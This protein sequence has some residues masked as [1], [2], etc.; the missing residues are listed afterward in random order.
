MKKRIA[1]ISS[2]IL[3]AAALVAAPVVFAQM[4]GRH[5]GH[6][7]GHAGGMGMLGMLD[8]FGQVREQLGLTDEQVGK[9][10]T[11]FGDLREQNEA[12]HEQMHGTLKDVA[13]TLIA[14]PNDV[15]AA[16]AKIEAQTAAEN[17]MKLNALNAASKALNVLT[18]EQRTKLGALLDEHFQQMESRRK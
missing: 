18:P 17:A 14:N 1:I 16:Q 4:H 9:I 7:F 8:H 3:V 2:T 13:R 15:A 6:G 12:F 11:I 10:H 5:G